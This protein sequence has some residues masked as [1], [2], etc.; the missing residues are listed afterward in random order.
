MKEL[1]RICPERFELLVYVAEPI[2]IADPTSYA[3]EITE[4]KSNNPHHILDCSKED[5]YDA[6]E[7]L[8]NG[9]KALFKMECK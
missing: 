7:A 8:N 6:K 2:G 5:F 4:P 1:F 3:W 9:V